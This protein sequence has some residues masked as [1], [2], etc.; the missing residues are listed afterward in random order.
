MARFLRCMS[1]NS[2]R[3]YRDFLTGPTVRIGCS[4]GFWGDTVTSGNVSCC[5]IIV[6]ILFCFIGPAPQLVGRGGID[7]L[8]ADYL[9]EITMSLL[10]TTKQKFPVGSC[11][12]L[13]KVI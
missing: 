4:S 7:F 3:T 8:V 9:S 1:T 12:N 2:T 5:K 6:S 11:I 13:L 10:A